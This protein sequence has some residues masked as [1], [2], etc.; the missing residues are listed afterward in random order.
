MVPSVAFTS[1]NNKKKA[2]LEVLKII[3]MSS[4]VCDSRCKSP[5]WLVSFAANWSHA[6][7]PIAKWP[8]QILILN[9]CAKVISFF[10]EEYISSLASVWRTWTY[11]VEIAVTIYLS[12]YKQRSSWQI[13]CQIQATMADLRSD[14][15]SINFR[16]KL[17]DSSVTSVSSH[18]FEIATSTVAFSKEI[19]K[20]S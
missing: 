11:N 14:Y 1:Y 4:L 2:L 19:K 8:G 13:A 12:Y 10:Y 17:L 20:V 16:M 6:T 3:Q 15:N 9:F 5:V 7:L 18:E